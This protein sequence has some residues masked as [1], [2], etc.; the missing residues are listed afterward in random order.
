MEPLIALYAIRVIA[1]WPDPTQRSN[2][3][4]VAKVN[5]ALFMLLSCVC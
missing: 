1:E 5:F 2:P 3:Q 4:I